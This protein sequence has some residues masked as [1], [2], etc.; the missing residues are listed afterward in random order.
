[1]YNPQRN[2]FNPENV[3]WNHCC[4][5]NCNERN[6][7]KSEQSR[8]WMKLKEVYDLKKKREMGNSI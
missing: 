1:M 3:I 6:T 8:N 7:D 2:Q 4:V 5:L